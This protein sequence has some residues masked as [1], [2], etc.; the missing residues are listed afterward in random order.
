MLSFEDKIL[1]EN[2]E[3]VKKMLEKKADIFERVHLVKKSAHLSHTHS[4]FCCVMKY[5]DD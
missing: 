4:C 5:R 3:N 2:R 1:I